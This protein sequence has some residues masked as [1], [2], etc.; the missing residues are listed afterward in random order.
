MGVMLRIDTYDIGSHFY[1][2]HIWQ[3]LALV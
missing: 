3:Y 2:Y 1:N